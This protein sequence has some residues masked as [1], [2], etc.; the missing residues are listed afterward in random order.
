[1]K[2]MEKLDLPTVSDSP[3]IIAI[4]SENT[5]VQVGPW[6]CSIEEDLIDET[7]RHPYYRR[8][9]ARANVEGTHLLFI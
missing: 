6:I 2:E 7:G 1:M 9:Y 3:E 5:E 8:L 4:R